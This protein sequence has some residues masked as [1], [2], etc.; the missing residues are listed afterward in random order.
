MRSTRRTRDRGPQINYDK[1]QRL[2]LEPPP[3]WVIEDDGHVSHE[4]EVVM[5]ALGGRERD[6]FHYITLI[7]WP[8]ASGSFAPLTP[9]RLFAAAVAWGHKP[10]DRCS[11]RLV[12]D[13]R[14]I[15]GVA[16]RALVDGQP[17][18]KPKEPVPVTLDAFARLLAHETDFSKFS[19]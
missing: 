9:E 16:F 4:L 2:L 11:P 15:R 13:K 8:L 17:G 12:Q 6:G 14:G 5:Y 1:H 18:P 3:G 7:F 19:N 10:G